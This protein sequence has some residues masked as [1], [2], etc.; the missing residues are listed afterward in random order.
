M[1]TPTTAPGSIYYER[2]EA[3]GRGGDRAAEGDGAINRREVITVP[4]HAR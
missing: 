4:A 3:R 2:W 1:S